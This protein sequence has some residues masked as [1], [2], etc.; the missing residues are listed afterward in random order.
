MGLNDVSYLKV[1][2][3]KYM[4]KVRA[5]SED[6]VESGGPL[7]NYFCYCDVQFAF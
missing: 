7:S 1:V 2:A 5:E 4:L 6:V 3:G